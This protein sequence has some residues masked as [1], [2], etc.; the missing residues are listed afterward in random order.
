MSLV[1]VQLPEP[2]ISRKL[3]CLRLFLFYVFQKL[4]DSFGF[5]AP[6]ME[7]RQT[8]YFYLEKSACIPI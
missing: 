6:H 2:K 5:P 8:Q 3:L 1:R 7:M 4:L